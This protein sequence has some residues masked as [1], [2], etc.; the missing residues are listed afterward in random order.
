MKKSVR[1]CHC[2]TNEIAKHCCKANL[3]FNWDQRKVVHRESRSTSRKIKE[4]IQ[5][6]KNPNHISKISY[7]LPAS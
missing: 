4:T 7:M 2:D 5:S 3:N 1:N 6:V